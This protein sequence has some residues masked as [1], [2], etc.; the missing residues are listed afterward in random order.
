MLVITSAALGICLIVCISGL[1]LMY[2]HFRGT[3]EQLRQEEEA[4]KNRLRQQE[5]LSVIAQSFISPEDMRPLIHN[6]L[7]MTGLFFEVSRA[8]LARFNRDA[9]TLDFEYEWIN[10]KH[11]PPSLLGQRIP[12]RPGKLPYDALITRGEVCLICGNIE[13]DSEMARL[14]GPWG[15]RAFMYVPV[16]IF[17]DFW[18]ILSLD[19]SQKG[20]PWTEGDIHLTRLIA[21]AVTGLIIRANAE[22]E[23]V[24]AK[25]LAEDSSRAKSNFLSRMSHE[26]RTPMN[27]IIGMTAIALESQDKKKIDYCLDRINNATFYLLGLIN[28]ILDMSRIEEGK[29]ELSSSEFD[30]EKMLKKVTGMVSLPIEE[31]KQRFTVRIEKGVPSRIIADEERL[32]QVLAKLLSNAA[33]F[34]PEQG[35]I[36]L[37]VKKTAG[38]DN[39]CTLCFD[40]VDSGIGISGEQKKKL[41]ELFEQG[42]GTMARRY[43]G[44]GLGL[45]LS[46]SIIELMGGEIRVASEPGKGSAFTVEI[47]VEQGKTGAPGDTANAGE[48]GPNT[49][50]PLPRDDSGGAQPFSG[51]IMLLAEDVEINREI[52]MS[53]LEDTGIR[54]ECAVNGAEALRFFTRNPAK[55]DIILMDIHMPEMDGYEATSLIRASAAPEAKTVPIIAMTANVFQEDIDKCLEAGM[56]GHLG[57][58]VDFEKLM[59]QLRKYLLRQN[60]PEMKKAPAEL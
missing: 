60:A 56:N 7:A 4:Q 42:D 5:L 27:A 34:T 59:A 13:E 53:L 49:G 51:R 17:G 19:R 48:A 50:L 15:M 43:G 55:Y 14:L 47:A 6:A 37:S 24:A 2:R 54:I 3:T 57:K 38:R 18:G 16:N 58:P 39:V 33:K 44:T 25:E 30:F 26:M 21:G 35:T 32:S 45:A 23:L 9:N 36:S 1:I 10:G 11:N 52:I 40:V 8:S 20:P 12:F 22:Q 31:K 28:D 29:L 41:F 46:K